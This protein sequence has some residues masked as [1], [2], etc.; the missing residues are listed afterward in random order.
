MKLT[1][2]L[3]LAPALFAQAQY[4]IEWS[5]WTGGDAASSGGAYVVHATV[6]APAGDLSIGGSYALRG[7]FWS[8][9]TVV[10]TGDAPALRIVY[11]GTNIILAWPD[12]SAGYRLQSSPSLSSPAWTDVNTPP[13]TVGNEWQ[14]VQSLAPGVRFYRL[15]QP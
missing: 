4:T 10:E 12:S 5:D 1:L 13:G 2:A 3:I 11:T 7:G 8:A 15:R 6:G 9:F 14:I